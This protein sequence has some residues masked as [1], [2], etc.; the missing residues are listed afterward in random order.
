MAE[1]GAGERDEGGREA[2]AEEGGEDQQRPTGGDA[3]G[4]AGAAQPTAR[5]AGERRRGRGGGAAPARRASEEGCV[6][7]WQPPSGS[8]RLRPSASMISSACGWS[9]HGGSGCP[10]PLGPAY[11]VS[12]RTACVLNET[13]GAIL[14]KTLVPGG[15]SAE[16]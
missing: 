13:E 7:R 16:R 10:D 9:G 4:G 2:D 5:N 6:Q 8:G 11:A 1:G 12:V 15:A 3:D 14:G